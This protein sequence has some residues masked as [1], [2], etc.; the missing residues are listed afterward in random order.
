MFVKT[1]YI[2]KLFCKFWY[3]SKILDHES[4]IFLSRMSVFLA[5]S[6]IDSMGADWLGRKGEGESFCPNK[7][8]TLLTIWDSVLFSDKKFQSESSKLQEFTLE[9]LFWNE[10]YLGVAMNYYQQPAPHTY[11]HTVCF[12]QIRIP[13]SAELCKKLGR[14]EQR[15]L[16]HPSPPPPPTRER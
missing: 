16:H 14:C 12:T 1:A 7:F 6:G 11:T 3:L 4:E 15:T 2:Y 5:A 8:L 9:S 10:T 13:P